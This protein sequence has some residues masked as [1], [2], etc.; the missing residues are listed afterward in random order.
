VWEGRPQEPAPYWVPPFAPGGEAPPAPEE[1]AEALHDATRRHLVADVPVG[2]FLSSGVDSVAVARLAARVAPGLQTY[3]VAFD[4]GGDESADAAAIATRLGLENTVVPVGASEA[5]ASVETFMGDMDQPTVDGLNSWIISRAVR[6]AGP[7]VAL[8][9]LGGDELFGGYSTFRHVPRIATAGRVAGFLAGAPGLAVNA[10]GWSAQTAHSRSRRALEATATGG[11]A[12]A[13]GAVRGL[14][15]AAELSRLWP[16]SRDLGAAV[17]AVPALLSQP[18]TGV[19]GALEMANYLPF[20]LL[21]DTDCMSMAHALEV[22]VPLLDDRVVELAVRGLSS[23]ESWDKTRL[24]AAVD[25]ALAYLAARPK[26]T[27]TLPIDRWMRGGLRNH[28]EDAVVSLGEANLGFDRRDLTN[29]WLGYLSGRVGW[30]PV[31]ALAV[32]GMWL[33]RRVAG[34]T[35]TTT[36][37]QRIHTS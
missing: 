27:F 9:G 16:T 5:L 25:P 11:W 37:P 36:P 18:A 15:G 34:S 7:V 13:Y 26:Q 14:F 21:R 32:L 29:L 2:L 1:L 23:G 10:L 24:L 6:N 35:T 28:T 12:S 17:V 20:Q 8:S 19:V 33:D 3:T 31:W 30:R 22:R 4:D